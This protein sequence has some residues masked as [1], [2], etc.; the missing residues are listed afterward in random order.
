M[1]IAPAT[2]TSA[3]QNAADGCGTE[4]GA[5]GDVIAR[6]VLAAKFDDACD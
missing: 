2:E 4:P 5:L 6:M 1:Q 3:P